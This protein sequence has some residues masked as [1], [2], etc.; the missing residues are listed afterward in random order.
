MM[1]EDEL[2]EYYTSPVRRLENNHYALEKSYQRL[3]EAIGL[4]HDREIYAATGEVLL[5]VMTTDEWH[6]RHNNGYSGRKNS[7]TNGQV[8]H[9]LKHAYNCMKHNMDFIKIHKKEGG[10]TFPIFFPLSVPPLIVLWMKS[11]GYL[12]GERPQQEKNYVKY[13]EGK[14]VLT[15]FD[16]AIS[17][18]SEERKRFY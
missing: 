15:T 7:D 2:K 9:G 17:F 1:N 8:L 13:I 3:R 12:K 14:E 16:V 18:L 11:E 4:N 10:F 6:I 5:W